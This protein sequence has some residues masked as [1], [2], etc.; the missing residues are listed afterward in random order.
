MT[1]SI[2]QSVWNLERNIDRAISHSRHMLARMYSLMPGSPMMFEKYERE[3]SRIEGLL[4]AGQDRWLFETARDLP[5]NATIVEIGGYKGKSTT[6]FAFTCAGT[7]KH[8]YTIDTFN[9]NNSDFT[10]S[11]RRDFYDT[12]EQNLERNGLKQY[13]TPLIGT[14]QEVARKWKGPIDLL[15]IDGSHVYDDVLADFNNFYPY[16]RRGALVAMHDVEPNHPDVVKVWEQ[17]VRDKLVDVG[18]C[19][20][21]AYG[22]KPAQAEG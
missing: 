13:V 11:G 5:D 15:Y 9:G 18:Y 22:R 14:S 10:G 21:L 20:T 19:R 1:S 2:R 7:G 17:V 6:C 8:V 16:V 3:I 4:C 12:W